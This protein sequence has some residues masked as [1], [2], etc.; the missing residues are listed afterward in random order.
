MLSKPENF[1]LNYSLLNDKMKS[2]FESIVGENGIERNY[3]IKSI[4]FK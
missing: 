3:L 4:T 2:H 1:I